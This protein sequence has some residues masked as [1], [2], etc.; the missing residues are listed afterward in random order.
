ML[1]AYGRIYEELLRP[2]RI[3]RDAVVSQREGLR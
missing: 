2:A 1:A 3:S